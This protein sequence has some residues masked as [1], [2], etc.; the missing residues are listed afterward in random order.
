MPELPEAESI[1]RALSRAI[2]GAVITG[3]EI[4]SPR[5]RSSLL[6][7][8]DA[9]LSGRRITRVRRRG[10]YVCADLDDMRTILMHFGMSGVVRVEDASIP[11]RKHEH[12]FLHFEDGRILRFECTRRFSL[13]EVHS[14][15]AVDAWPSVLAGLGPEPLTD[16]FS[17]AY[18]FRVSRQRR[19]PVKVFL[20][21]N[22]FVCGIGNIYAAE[23]LFAS[24]VSPLRPAGELSA[25][26]C[27]R[28]AADAKKILC[29]AIELGGTTVSD[30]KNVDGSE[31]KFVQELRM[32]GCKGGECP[33]CQ[34]KI[35]EVRLGGR[36]SCYC[37]ECQK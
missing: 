29:R 33:V 9:Q 32:Y 21:D 34:T 31:G 36:S 37:P 11:R 22:R 24:G 17:G 25:G 26:E 12:V 4:F 30:F 15:P 14:L 27:E 23:I 18:L 1:C 2:T 35:A 16:E 28:I 3:V 6:G 8:P 5:M 13:F 7:L 10:R 20:M 19:T